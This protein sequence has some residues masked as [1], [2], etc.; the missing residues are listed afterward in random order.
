MALARRRLDLHQ[1][2]GDGLG[3]LGQRLIPPAVS[4]EDHP[5]D[6]IIA[7]LYRKLN[8]TSSKASG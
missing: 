6:K 5:R 8:G 2:R 4:G 1:E 7:N 3:E